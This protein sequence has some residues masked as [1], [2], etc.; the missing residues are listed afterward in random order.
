MIQARLKRSGA[1]WKEEKAEAMLAL[2][3]RRASGLLTPQKSADV[4]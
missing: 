4:E 1:W 3:T 2:R